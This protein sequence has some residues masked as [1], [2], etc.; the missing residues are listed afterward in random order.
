MAVAI[1]M[2]DLLGGGVERQNLIIAEE[3]QRQGANVSLVLHRL[4]GDLSEQVPAGLRVIDLAS[5]RT[6]LDVPRLVSFLRAE[7][8]DILLA[9]LD[10]NNVAALLAKALSF[11]AT[12]VVICQHNSMGSAF[13]ADENWLYRWIPV[14][15]RLLAPLIA[16]AVAVSDGVAAELKELCGL[17]NAQVLTITNPVV[18]PDFITR[19]YYAADHAWL[20]QTAK[21]TFITA[22][23]LVA[24]KDHA[25]MIRALAIHR[26]RFDSRLLILGG[27]PLKGK[28]QDLVMELGLSQSVDLIGF[29]SNALPF[30]RQADAFLLSSRS[31]GFGNVIVE[32]LGCGTPVIATACDYGPAQILDNGRYGVLVEPNHPAALAGAMDEV[33]TLRERFPAK[34][35]RQRAEEFSVAACTLRYREMFNSLVTRSG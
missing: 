25:T 23:R 28:L 21:P 20:Q 33:A 30:I 29:Q 27:G 18:G 10:L 17:S 5:S 31:E 16:R 15:Y 6:L 24:Q 22:G 35:L 9:N 32:A 12:K 1:Y 4:R 8:P 26:A 13:T 11:S 34:L 7:K 14:F 2:Y 19:S 3:L